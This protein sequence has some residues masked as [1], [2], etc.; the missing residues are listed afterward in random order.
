MQTLGEAIAEIN[1]RYGNEVCKVLIERDL[2]DVCKDPAMLSQ[3][4]VMIDSSLPPAQKILRCLALG[5][6]FGI[7]TTRERQT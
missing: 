1:R 3:A 2:E 5:V 4:I 6:L 7:E